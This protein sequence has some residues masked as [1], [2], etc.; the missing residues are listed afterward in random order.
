M[1]PKSMICSFLLLLVITGC[2]REEEDNQT[3]KTALDLILADKLRQNADGEGLSKY[4]LPLD[5]QLDQI[6]QDPNNPLTAEKVSL[7]KLLFHETALGL[8]PMH[9][10]NEGTYSCASC[11]FASAGFQAGRHQ[12]ISDGGIG[13]GVNGEG[14]MPD[15]TYELSELDVQPIRTPSA[16]NSAY[17]KVNLWNGQFGAVG[18]NVGTE[19]EWTPDTPKETNNLGFEGVETQ[20]IAAMT[21]HRLDMDE[22]ICD[23]LGYR[24]LFDAAFPDVPESERYGKVS[25]GLAIAAYERTLLSN[26]APFQRWLQGEN[27]VMSD[28]EK[29]G[30]I[31]FF[32]KANCA[33]CHDGPN[34]ANMDF[35]AIGL[36]DLDETFEAS[37]GINDD[38]Q[39]HLG[40]Y[41]F[42][43]VDADMYK[44]K[45][46]QLYNLTD[47]PFY[48]HG[49]SF[50][51]IWDV[52]HYK[53]QAI[54]ENPEVPNSQLAEEFIPLGLTDEEIGYITTFVENSLRDPD[55]ARFQPDALPSG[56][57]FP[58]NDDQSR[59]DL[60]CN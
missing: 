43:K 42:T 60:G 46:P 27:A 31:L 39:E 51:N 54:K 33:S 12:G 32:G 48:G 34:L 58:N 10:E 36:K 55:L 22:N 16:L 35:K 2:Q 28:E 3:P 1:T 23:N 37:Y 53:N 56:N 45:I 15:P 18:P 8:S 14:R 57:C 19:A 5:G 26:Q 21:V 50:R 9:V 20:A 30:A 4:M 29:L 7:G 44:F 25:A 38:T 17:Q 13:F 41:S 40:R 59:E 49:S 6:P 47:S 11:H 52:I 24:E